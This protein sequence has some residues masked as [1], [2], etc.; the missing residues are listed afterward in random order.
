MDTRSGKRGQPPYGGKLTRKL[1]PLECVSPGVTAANLPGLCAEKTGWAVAVLGDRSV[2]VA[3]RSSL[4]ARGGV[5]AHLR[6][7]IPMST[8]DDSD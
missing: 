1:K 4:L 8:Y 2:P 6:Q 7:W 5:C 3:S